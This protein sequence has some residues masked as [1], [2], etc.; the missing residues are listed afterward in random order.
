[1]IRVKVMELVVQLSLIEFLCLYWYI[2][3]WVDCLRLLVIMW[4]WAITLDI[5]SRSRW[6]VK[7]YGVGHIFDFS[8]LCL[9][10]LHQLFSL[11]T[12]IVSVFGLKCKLKSWYLLNVSEA[13]WRSNMLIV[14]VTIV[15]TTD[16]NCS[17]A[18]RKVRY[19]NI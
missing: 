15:K 2:H 6:A 18:W 13:E 11:D 10:L 17:Q 19:Y 9:T 5:W 1:M 4:S 14:Q 7:K 3:I 12:S 16:L 8:I